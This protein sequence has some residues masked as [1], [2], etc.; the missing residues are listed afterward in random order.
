MMR[1]KVKVGDRVIVSPLGYGNLTPDGMRYFIA[2]GFNSLTGTCIHESVRFGYCLVRF[3]NKFKY[4]GHHGKEGVN[5]VESTYLI[6]IDQ[7]IK[8]V[9]ITDFEKEVK[10]DER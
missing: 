2:N 6:P 4:F 5:I 1:G 7:K 9:S 3:D 8:F 10:T